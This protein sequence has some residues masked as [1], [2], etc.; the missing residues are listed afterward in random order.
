MT[1]LLACLKPAPKWFVCNGRRRGGLKGEKQR[2]YL[3]FWSGIDLRGKTHIL[4]VGLLA[5]PALFRC[6]RSLNSLVKCTTSRLLLNCLWTHLKS[7]CL[8]INEVACTQH[9]SSSHTYL[10]PRELQHFSWKPQ[11]CVCVF[12]LSKFPVCH[13]LSDKLYYRCFNWVLSWL[14]LIQPFHRCFCMVNWGHV[15]V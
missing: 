12:T 7:T 2:F 1:L 10:S 3:M 8:H 11:Y 15:E 4:K 13:F 9:G 14:L 5:S 6:Q